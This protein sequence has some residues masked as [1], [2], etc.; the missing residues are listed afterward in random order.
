MFA[1]LPNVGEQLET[2]MRLSS[3]ACYGGAGF[4]EGGKGAA[5]AIEKINDIVEQIAVDIVKELKREHLTTSG[6]T[7]LEWQRRMSRT[8]S[9][10]MI[11]CLKVCRFKL[12]LPRLRRTTS[13]IRGRYQ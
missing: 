6:E 13:L 3:A 2:V 1:L 11:R 8:T 4:G 12:P 5:P 10:L 9:P 7:F